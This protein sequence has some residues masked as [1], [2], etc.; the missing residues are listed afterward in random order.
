MRFALLILSVAF[1]TSG[2][3]AQELSKEQLEPWSALTQQLSLIFQ[4]EWK[5]LDKYIHPQIVNWGDSMPS[6]IHFGDEAKKYF[7]QVEEG[8]D[9][10]VAFHLVPVSVVVAGDVAIINAYLHVLTKPDGKSVEKIFRLHNTWK[11]ED[12]RW[13]LLATYNTTIA[14][15]DSDD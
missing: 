8:A 6:P 12:G 10:V 15:G 7:E 4:R 1:L 14:S 2:S 11:R 9:K 13:Q 5:E 3:S